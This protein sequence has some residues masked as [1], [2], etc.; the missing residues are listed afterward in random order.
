M[1]DKVVVVNTSPFIFL[2]KFGKLEA[3]LEL[4][5]EIYSS[6]GVRSEIKFPQRVVEFFDKFVVTRAVKD[7]ELDT[8]LSTRF[9]RFKLGE[10]ES[11]ILYKEINADEL[12]FA[13]TY[14]ESLARKLGARVRDISEIP[15]LDNENKIFL[16]QQS[17]CDYYLSLWVAGYRPKHLRK[18]L[19]TRGL[20]SS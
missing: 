14:A 10:R 11:Y 16:D 17:I 2:D 6:E 9:K 8:K 15:D 5:K 13:N 4:Y 1:K 20:I 12:L 7:L 19:V 3:L 18:L